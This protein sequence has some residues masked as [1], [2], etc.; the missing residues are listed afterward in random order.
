MWPFSA[1]VEALTNAAGAILWAL[2]TLYSDIVH[3]QIGNFSFESGGGGEIEPVEFRPGP[4]TRRL[5]AI[6]YRLR[7]PSTV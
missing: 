6:N 4:L 7:P 1:N 5:A 2:R 3:R